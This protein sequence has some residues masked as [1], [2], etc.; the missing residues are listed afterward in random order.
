MTVIL[1]GCFSIDRSY[2]PYSW[3]HVQYADAIISNQYEH[4]GPCFAG[5]GMA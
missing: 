4:S 3:V 5:P 1:M 2:K